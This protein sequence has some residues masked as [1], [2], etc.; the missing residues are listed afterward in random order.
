MWKFGFV[1]EVVNG[2]ID[3]CWRRILLENFLWWPNDDKDDWKNFN[4]VLMIVEV[5]KDFEKC[6][7][8]LEK[9]FGSCLEMVETE[10]FEEKFV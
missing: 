5:I 8:D 1:V 4:C 10:N 9:K 3:F 7:W 6:W 2:E